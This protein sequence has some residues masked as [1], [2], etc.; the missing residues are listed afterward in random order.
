MLELT[1]LLIIISILLLVIY[2]RTNNTNSIFK[3]N[4]D[5]FYLKSC[6]SGYKSYYDSDGNT[7]CCFGQI[8]ANR[9]MS[10]NQ[11]TLNG[12]G[13]N[14]LP[15]CVNLLQ[16][17]FENKSNEY[18]TSSLPN[19][20]EDRDKNIKGCTSGQLNEIMTGPKNS[21]QPK[22]FIYS[23]SQENNI[24]VDSCLNQK[25]L[26]SV[27]CFGN[28]C[29]KQLTQANKSLPPL[30]AVA[31]TDSLGMHRVSYTRESMENFLNIS[32]PNW[33]N[34]GIDLSK[35]INI[36]EVAKAFYIDKTIDQ[37]EIQF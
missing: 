37:S 22:C 15:N 12:K 23:S 34:Q 14:E 5:N 18:C 1:I 2:F 9:C 30:V 7:N 10:D 26:D 27:E 29:T 31:F 32:N 3:E 21:N 16:T 24:S 33:R 35:N 25:K 13:T 28:N 19:Y 4:F 17:L 8:V 20:F 6:P 11:C 36:A